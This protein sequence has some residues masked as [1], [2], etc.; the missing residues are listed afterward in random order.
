MAAK[1]RGTHPHVIKESGL[2]CTYVENALIL[3]TR[4]ILNDLIA[5]PTDESKNVDE[6]GGRFHASDTQANW[7]ERF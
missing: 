5:L 3:L 7:S 6:S 4:V 1:G 2:K